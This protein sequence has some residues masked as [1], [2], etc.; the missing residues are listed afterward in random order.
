M[1]V[2]CPID[3]YVHVTVTRRVDGSL[4]LPYDCEKAAQAAA[5]VR[6]LM[7]GPSRFG[8]EVAIDSPLPRGR[9]YASSTADVVGVSAAMAAA[10]GGELSAEQLGCLAC[11]IE[12]SDSIMFP[13]W[14]AFAYH[15]GAWHQPL[16]TGLH[17]PLVILDPGEAIDTVTFNRT[18][19]LKRVA[20]L[21]SQTR[22]ALALL[23]AGAQQRR[24]DLLGAASRLSA[25]AYQQAHHSDLVEQALRW[26]DELSARGVV[27]AHSG[28]IVGVL[29]DS[30]GA[31]TEAKAWLGSRFY[32]EVTLAHTTGGGASPLPPLLSFGD[33]RGGRGRDGR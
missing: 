30:D 22:E 14:A 21:E 3:R 4:S 6:E 31:A 2:S 10:L 29:F 20:V 9:G 12:P 19:D 32:G 17:L 18:L 11:E 13:G 16:G 26:A 28:S 7:N 25:M 15:S 8:A 23:T 1:L 5:R 33:R 24:A 27:R